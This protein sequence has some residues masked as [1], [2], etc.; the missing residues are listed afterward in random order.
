MTRLS[1]LVAASTYR[2]TRASGNPLARSA[3]ARPCSNAR[4]AMRP[5]LRRRGNPPRISV[6][7][8]SDFPWYL[9]SVSADAPARSFVTPT[10]AK[11]RAN[12]A[13]PRALES[14]P[15]RFPASRHARSSHSAP[16][17]SSRRICGWQQGASATDATA[18]RPGRR[19]A[20]ST[21]RRTAASVAPAH[22]CLATTTAEGG[23]SASL[24]WCGARL[25]SARSSSYA[26]RV[27]STTTRV[28][29]GVGGS[30][31]AA[32]ADA[33]SFSS[34]WPSSC[35]DRGASPVSL[36]STATRG[37]L[38]MR[39]TSRPRSAWPAPS[40]RTTRSSRGSS[41]DSAMGATSL[42]S[43]SSCGWCRCRFPAEYHVVRGASSPPTRRSNATAARCAAVVPSRKGTDAT[44]GASRGRAGGIDAARDSS[45][46]AKDS[47]S[48]T[49]AASC[50]VILLGREGRA[51]VR[52]R[53]RT[54]TQPQRIR[55]SLVYPVHFSY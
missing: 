48:A 53:R 16:L 38:V 24:R 42:A 17:Y 47:A 1:G 11:T 49:L 54:P 10:S 51:R 43:A 5:N 55:L 13:G 7:A 15:I 9:A 31:S 2:H 20:P 8:P 34:S 25:A 41:L 23:A 14:A 21:T 4:R 6:N 28:I 44:S 46:A 33:S 50:V 26:H 18:A 32:G 40:S 29:F 36:L 19:V 52:L 12:P 30:D 27:R 22:R 39:E 3:S 45:L 35:E 37:A